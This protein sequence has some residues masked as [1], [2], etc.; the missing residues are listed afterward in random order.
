MP[1]RFGWRFLPLCFAGYAQ[2]DPHKDDRQAL[3]KILS[4]VEKAINAQ[5]IEGIIAQMRADCTVT[6]WNAEISRGYGEIRA[7]Y[8]R[9]ERDRREVRWPMEN[10]EPAPLIECVQ[11]HLDR[12]ANAGALVRRRGGCRDRRTRGLVYRPSPPEIHLGC[13]LVCCPAAAC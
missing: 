10:R 9:M 11:Q 3:L 4:E 6:W 7:Y 12:R 8:R 5:D 13:L 2:D 1:T